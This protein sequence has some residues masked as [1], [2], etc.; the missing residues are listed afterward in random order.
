MIHLAALISSPRY[1]AASKACYCS[2]KKALAVASSLKPAQHPSLK[3]FG[4]AYGPWPSS[5]IRYVRGLASMSDL[6]FSL[7]K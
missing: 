2:R 3:T 4:S 5:V 7:D 1:S 6:Y